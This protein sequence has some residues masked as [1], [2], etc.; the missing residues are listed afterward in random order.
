MHGFPYAY[1]TPETDW[2]F[3][4]SAI[5]TFRPG[6]VAPRAGAFR[7]DQLRPSYGGGLRYMLDR[8]EKL[9]LRVD[10]GFGNGISG[11]YFNIR[12]AF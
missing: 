1:Y 6:G 2:A 9:T 12:E 7:L 11:L 3:G 5:V 4:G 10:A 8:K